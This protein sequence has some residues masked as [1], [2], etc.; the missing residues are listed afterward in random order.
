MHNLRDHGRSRARFADGLASPF[1]AYRR[2]RAGTVDVDDAVVDDGGEL[3]AEVAWYLDRIESALA[4]DGADAR[5]AHPKLGAT[6]DRAVQLWL[7]REKVV[8][9]CFYRAT[10]R[11]LR[12][13][14]SRALERE[15]VRLAAE[16]LGVQPHQDVERQ[17]DRARAPV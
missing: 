10:G 16:Q 7:A 1:E 8:I 9:F 5:R 17:I 14:I 3:P 6:A 12:A 15:T 11:A 13:H 4:D 2:T